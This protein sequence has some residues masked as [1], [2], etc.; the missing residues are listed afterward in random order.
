MGLVS[1]QGL[2]TVQVR[3]RIDQIK[4]E[5]C[6]RFSLGEAGVA[7]ARARLGDGLTLSKKLLSQKE[8]D[9]SEV[10]VILPSSVTQGEALRFDAGWKLKP[11]DAEFTKVADRL[12]HQWQVAPSY[13]TNW[14]LASIILEFLS[15][16]KELVWIFENG[17]ARPSDPYLKKI[18]GRYFT[19]GNEVYHFLTHEDDIEDIK[20]T[21]G[22]ASTWILIGVLSIISPS[23]KFG[24]KEIEV[25]DL[26]FLANQAKFVTVDAYDREA[27]LLCWLQ[28]HYIEQ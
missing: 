26:E 20:E 14:I 19:C 11:A 13:N 23:L 6:K 1:R 28:S 4:F 12:G 5:G 2:A 21:V 16:N 9:A 27:N 17:S 7:Y 24:R 15:T 25:T 3:Q 18:K 22:R 8:I 10:S